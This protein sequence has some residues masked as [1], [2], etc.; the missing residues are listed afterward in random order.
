MLHKFN[1]GRPTCES[2]DFMQ[3]C[4]RCSENP[5]VGDAK[6]AM[7]S[8]GVSFRLHSQIDNVIHL[9]QNPMPNLV[10]LYQAKN[11]P[12][13]YA[14]RLMLEESG[15]PIEIANDLLQRAV[16][17]LPMGG[18]TALRLLVEES[19]LEAARS[20]IASSQ[21]R[22]SSDDELDGF[23]HLTRCLSCGATLSKNEEIC[24]QCGWTYLTNDPSESD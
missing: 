3:G 17:A 23:E 22:V 20:L 2:R 12:D 15:I 7:D 4:G 14:V 11:L 1:V 9:L 13:A 5:H 24:P 19:Q 21:L 8:H 10:E 6:L 16:G 18:S